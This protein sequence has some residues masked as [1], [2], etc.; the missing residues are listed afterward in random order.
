M[1]S[2]AGIDLT[3]SPKKPS[4]YALLGHSLDLRTLSDLGS[5]SEI[6]E[7]LVADQPVVIAIDSPLSKPKALHCF[8]TECACQDPLPRGREC[9]RQL[10]REGIA[11]YFT[12][13]KSIIKVM[14]QRAIRL[15]EELRGRGFEVIEVYPYA[16][17]VRLWASRADGGRIP[18]KTRPEGRKFI[19][20]RLSGLLPNIADWEELNH[21]QQ[22]AVVA[23][24]TAYLYYWGQTQAV[25]DP[26]EGQI[27]VPGWL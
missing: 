14:I 4:A 15:Q 10:L 18:R 21:D 2:F 24:Y 19:Q 25:G 5:D 13:K 17:K 8:E 1:A 6:I 16:S 12:T 26:D 23:A 22:D 7:A 20:A 9:E 3:A 27:H 11:S